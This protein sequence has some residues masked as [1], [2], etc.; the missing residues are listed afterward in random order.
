MNGYLKPNIILVKRKNKDGNFY[1]F[2]Q[3]KKHEDYK[4][5]FLQL[6]GDKSKTAT[7]FQN[8]RKWVWKFSI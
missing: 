7:K 5:E 8:I 6:K 2:C 4:V 3:K 1:Q